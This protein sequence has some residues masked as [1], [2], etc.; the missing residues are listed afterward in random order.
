MQE[1]IRAAWV[2]IDTQKAIKNFENVRKRAKIANENTKVCAVVKAN[3][4][5]MGA[6]ELSKLYIK[7]GVDMLSVAVITEA[8]ELRKEIGS[9]TNMP[10]LVM[11]YTPDSYFEDAI[12]N[13]ITLTL[14][15]LE[16][17][18]KLD[19]IANN[20]NLTAK[21]HIKIETG[22]NRLGFLP[23]KENA[24]IVKKISDLKNIY[25]EGIFTHF[26]RADEKDKT[27][28]HNQAKLFIDFNELLVERGLDIAIKHAANSATIVDLP[29]Y[30][31]NMVRPG[32]IL[33]GSYPSDEVD[34]QNIDVDF[35]ITL[36]AQLANV[37]TVEADTG[38][39]YGHK[40]ITNKETI[41]GTLPFGYADGFSRNLSNN[42]YVM[43]KG[44][45]CPQLGR[46]CMDQIMVDL[47]EVENPQ[48]GDV[49]IVYGDGSDGALTIDDVATMRNTI[50]YEVASTLSTRLPRKYI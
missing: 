33:L 43:V 23:T 28:T 8:L 32:I 36:K 46:I 40:Y 29:E 48:I 47:S 19:K 13:D 14:F 12:N 39:S 41:I 5:G 2:E 24:D 37:K 9:E 21:I 3:S 15:T 20:L 16:Q 42:F 7:N 11:G 35:C 10:L 44:V 27:A 4:Y 6:V 25:I 50:S 1:K 22:M 30:Y 17:A 49:A 38:I 18:Q 26:A 45:K 34:R 31:F